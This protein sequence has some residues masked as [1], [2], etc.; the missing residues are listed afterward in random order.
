M[1]IT[2]RIEEYIN[3]QVREK[4]EANVELRAL[5]VAADLERKHF[6]AAYQAIANNAKAA[7][8]Q[9]LR[10]MKVDKPETFTLSLSGFWNVSDNLPAVIAYH[11]ACRKMDKKIRATVNEILVSMEMGGDKETLNQLLEAVSFE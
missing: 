4:A 11:E 6:D 8:T 9:L 10:D 3:K 5:K 2:K 7:Y 1:R